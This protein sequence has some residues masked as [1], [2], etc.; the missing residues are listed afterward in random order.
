MR[1]IRALLWLAVKIAL[2]F[3][4]GTLVLVR[5]PVESAGP[6]SLALWGVIAL[7]CFIDLRRLGKGRNQVEQSASR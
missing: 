2:V 7:L 6:V 1:V 3:M 5:L 4:L